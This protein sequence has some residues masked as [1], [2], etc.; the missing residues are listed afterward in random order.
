LQEIN[1][2]IKEAKRETGSFREQADNASI[3]EQI[4]DKDGNHRFA[5]TDNQI[6]Q[7]RNVGKYMHQNC[8]ICLEYITKEGDTKYN[9]STFRCSHCKMPLCK[10]DR[11]N[12]TIGWNYSCIEEHIK[13]T[14]EVVGCHGSDRSYSNFPKEQQV[15]IVSVCLTSNMQG[16]CRTSV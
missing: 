7:G 15:Q 2:A 6:R 4:T 10:K 9:Q 8:F 3:L 16:E 14:F 5:V 13:T 11:S 12:P 1:G